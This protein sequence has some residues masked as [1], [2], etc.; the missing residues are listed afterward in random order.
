MD[1]RRRYLPTEAEL[2]AELERERTEAERVLRS[3]IACSTGI[4]RPASCASTRRSS[5]ADPG[6][7]AVEPRE[8]D[9]VRR[10]ARG[11]PP[12]PLP[13]R[14]GVRTTVVVC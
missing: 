10:P 12:A 1:I 6:D 4:P 2:A 7:V 5:G 3:A 14:R 8:M 11:S 13:P 9:A